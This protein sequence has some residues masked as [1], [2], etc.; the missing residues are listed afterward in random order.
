MG[1]MR[2][3]TSGIVAS[4]LVFGLVSSAFASSVTPEAMAEAGVRMNQMNIVRGQVAGSTDLQL[5]TPIIRA[6]L[7]TIIVRAFG[8][9]ETAKLLKGLPSFPDVTADYWATGEILMAKRLIEAKG[10]TVGYTDGTFRPLQSVTNAEAVAFLL[11][12]LGVEIPANTSWPDGYFALAAQKGVLTQADVDYIKPIANEKAVRGLVFYIADNAFRGYNYEAGKTVYTKYV[13]GVKP[14]V[15]VDELALTTVETKVT[16]TGTAS[17]NSGKVA[18][19]VNG[20]AV[21]VVNGKFT[22]SVDLKVGANP[23]NVTASDLAGNVESVNKSVTRNAGDAA[24][25]TATLGAQMLKAGQETELKIVV[26]DKNG[27]EI[28]D[29]DVKVETTEGLGTYAAGKFTAGTKPMAGTVTVKAGEAAPVVLDVVVTAGALAKIKVEGAAA[30]KVGQPIT[31]T[32]KGFDAHDN[33]VAVEGA[34]WTNTAGGVINPLTGEFAGTRSGNVTVTAKVGEL[35]GTA[36]VAVYADAAALKIDAPTGLIANGADTKTVTVRVVDAEGVTVQNATAKVTLQVAAAS[37]ILIK[38]GDNKVT[39]LQADAVNG[40]ATFTVIGANSVFTASTVTFSATSGTLTGD[41]ANVTSV[42]PTV[43]KVV[44]TKT[45]NTSVVESAGTVTISAKI[46]DSTGVQ[47]PAPAAF[48]VPLTSSNTTTASLP[49]ASADSKLAFAAGATAPTA[50]VTLTLNPV[51][52]DVTIAGTTTAGYTI[53]GFG[54]TSKIAGPIYKLAI[55][56]APKDA[57]ADNGVITIKV[58]VQDSLG[59]TKSTLTTSSAGTGET[60]RTVVA[61]A[62]KGSTTVQTATGYITNGVATLTF[63]AANSNQLTEATTYSFTV[64]ST[65]STTTLVAPTETMTAK[66]TPGAANKFGALTASPATLVANGAQTSTLSVEIQDQHGNVVPTATNEVTFSRTNT[67]ALA[68]TLPTVMKAT[69]VNGKASIVVTAGVTDGAVDTFQ[70]SGKINETTF[71]GGSS[72]ALNQATV[73]TQIVGQ[74]AGM[75]LKSVSGD[76]VAVAT[77]VSAGKN[78]TAGVAYDVS[79]NMVDATAGGARVVSTDNGRSVVIEA[80]KVSD[81]SV[82]ATQTV[83]TVNGVAKATFNMEKAGTYYFKAVSTIAG[84]NVEVSTKA[85]TSVVGADTFYTGRS[86]VKAAAPASIAIKPLLTSVETG[87][88]M[89]V[90]LEA[91]DAFGNA[92]AG[93]ATNFTFANTDRISGSAPTWT[94]TASNAAET[95]TLADSDAKASWTPTGG[96]AVDNLPV[97]AATITTYIAGPAYQLK[98]T[99]TPAAVTAGNAATVKVGVYDGAGNLKT[100]DNGTVVTLV[101]NANNPAVVDTDADALTAVT[102]TAA[103]GIATFTLNGAVTI[104]T[105]N[106]EATSGTLVKATGISFAANA[107]SATKVL[108]NSPTLVADGSSIAI[109]TFK[110]ADTN[111]NTVSSYNGTMKFETAGTGAVLLSTSAPIVNGQAVVQVKATTQK[112]TFTVTPSIEGVTSGITMNPSTVTVTAGAAHSITASASA[113]GA[114][115]VVVKDVYGNSVE[116]ATVTATGTGTLTFGNTD[117]N[118]I[119]TGTASASGSYTITSGSATATVNVTITP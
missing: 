103:N 65:V 18:V 81:D 58:A 59:T 104:G 115:I 21:E 112:G 30:A 27:A 99:E 60:A 98:L 74:V 110:V 96:S 35:T 1:L 92:V 24:T 16:V 52:G 75:A 4:S 113:N 93:A 10:G 62:K 79:F 45:P 38:S 83:T 11:K 51:P 72:S 118:G 15:T 9:E 14:A 49:S 107:G 31:F 25:V 6:E 63:S 108:V 22:A 76:A 64:A 20:K 28:K 66:V 67:S 8:Q 56:E 109:L 2:K 44:L 88:A 116:G 94:Y 102:A 84:S 86:V 26:K 78:H 77:N 100:N 33:S 37:N 87:T 17:D 85:L 114:V 68:T 13:D 73:T 97:T 53:E 82:V 90:V 111:N 5:N 42:A 80:R 119:T 55:V 41:L 106:F 34:T 39:T 29:A 32:V 46:V 95:V 89:N 105:Y 57:S 71:L 50:N 54:L 69:P 48:E 47:I 61:T 3:L 70:V 40:V 101:L 19:T 23:I 36:T 43:G 12:F 7:V 117:A 91:K